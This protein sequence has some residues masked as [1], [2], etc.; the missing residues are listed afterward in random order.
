VVLEVI[1]EVSGTETGKGG[2]YLGRQQKDAICPDLKDI[3]K[4]YY[5]T[6]SSIERFFS[7]I[8]ENKR[9]SLRFDKLTHTFFSFFVLAAI[10][11]LG[12]IC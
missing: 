2:F 1:A 6:R 7:R 9:L 3:Y 12:L 5:R 10:R 4:P 11:S 8:K